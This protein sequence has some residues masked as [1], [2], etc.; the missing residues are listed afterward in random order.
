MYEDISEKLNISPSLDF[1]DVKTDCFRLF[2]LSSKSKLKLKIG[3]NIIITP[4]K[5]WVL[6]E[7]MKFKDDDD[8]EVYFN[9]Q[10]R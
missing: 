1:S 5:S 6:G 7:K 10:K 9:T 2:G 8:K 3:D 4:G